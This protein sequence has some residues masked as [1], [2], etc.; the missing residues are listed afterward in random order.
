MGSGGKMGGGYGYGYGG[1]VA[2][3]YDVVAGGYDVVVVD[4]DHA[5]TDDGLG[6]QCCEYSQV[7]TS[8]STGCEY[9]CVSF[10]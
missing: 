10:C 9:V 3:G 8:G 1:V 5:G 2:G 4:D 7:C 6:S